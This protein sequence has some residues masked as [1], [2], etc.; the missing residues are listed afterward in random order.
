MF[1][2]ALLQVAD[3]GANVCRRRAIWKV[4]GNGVNPCLEGSSERRRFI[5]PHRLENVGA[6]GC[7]NSESMPMKST[8]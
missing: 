3:G 4:D 5:R 8:G 1:K 6:G 2:E 7:S